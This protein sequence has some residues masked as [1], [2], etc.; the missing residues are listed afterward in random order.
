MEEV[1][2]P[3]GLFNANPYELPS[4]DIIVRQQLIMISHRDVDIVYYSSLLNFY[5]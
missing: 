5:T 3:K 2:I 1:Y 4:L